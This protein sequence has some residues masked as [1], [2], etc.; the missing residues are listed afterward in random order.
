[1]NAAG[2]S[3][4][5]RAKHFSGRADWYR[6]LEVRGSD[7]R[8]QAM[9]VQWPNLG[10]IEPVKPP[11]DHEGAFHVEVSPHDLPEDDPTLHLMAAVEQLSA[12]AGTLVAAGE[13]SP[14]K[15]RFKPPRIHYRRGEV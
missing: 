11:H 13:P 15:K 12:P 10:I 14:T 6:L 8:A 9:I 3:P 5:Q 1:L 7:T 2:T 4:A